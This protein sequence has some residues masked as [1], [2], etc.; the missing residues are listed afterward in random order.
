M[1]ADTKTAPFPR[2]LKEPTFMLGRVTNFRGL[3]RKT[4][5]I[6]IPGMPLPTVPTV[7]TVQFTPKLTV[8]VTKSR[9][10]PIRGLFTPTAIL[11]LRLVQTFAV[12]VRQKLLRLVRVN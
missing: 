5:V 7:L 1:S 2:L 8:L 10:S 3:P 9:P 6:A 4:V 11:N 12:I